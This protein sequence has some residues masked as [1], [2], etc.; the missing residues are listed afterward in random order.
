MHQKNRQ[1][2]T[3]TRSVPACIIPFLGIILV[4]CY[5]H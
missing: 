4:L 5:R 3:Q 2:K 1:M